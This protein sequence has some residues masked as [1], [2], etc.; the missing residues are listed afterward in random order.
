MF[1]IKQDDTLPFFQALLKTQVESDDPLPVDLTGAT[2]VFKMQ[3]SDGG[4]LKVSAPAVINNALTGDVQYEWVPADTDT[5][6][7]YL[8]EFEATFLSGDKLSFPTV[9]FLQVNVVTSF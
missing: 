5:V 9:G 6:G 8:A 1:L 4:P 3:P 2:V 7:A